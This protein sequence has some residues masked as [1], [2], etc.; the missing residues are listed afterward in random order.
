MD[1]RLGAAGEARTGEGMGEGPTNEAC[2][3]EVLVAV[4]GCRSPSC[5]SK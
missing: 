4:L 5:S 3:D 2:G 1:S